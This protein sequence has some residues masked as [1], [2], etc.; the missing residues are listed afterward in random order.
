MRTNKLI[1]ITLALVLL[2]GN[3]IS[4]HLHTNSRW[5][6]CSIQLD[7][8]LTQDAWRQF[9][10]EAG[11]VTY[12]RPL[13]DA[14]PLGKKHFEIGILQWKTGIDDKDAAWNDTFVHP[15]ADHWLFEGS[16][17][18]FP[19]LTA[20]VGIT[21]KLDAG[22]Y[23]TKNPNA[24]Y[25]FYGGQVQYNLITNEEKKWSLAAR[26]GF[27]RLYGPED[28][29]LTTYGADALISKEFPL[30]VKW[31]S[32]SP[33]ATISG[34]L[35][36]SHEKTTRVDLKNETTLGAQAAAGAVLRLSVLRLAAEYNVARVST[37]SFKLGVAF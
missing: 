10:R 12:F 36:H 24:N 31:A 9:T 15:T 37:L 25:G 17:L 4:Q 35:S 7:P 20:R 27:T 19:G 5:E 29:N 33:Y 26:G 18:A 21:D 1:I 2:A 34:V 6:E 30:F 13:V 22:V 32:V 23:V 11:L 14:R 16:G 3:A 8:T 28:V